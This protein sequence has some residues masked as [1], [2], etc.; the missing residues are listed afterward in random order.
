MDEI[1][2]WMKL[3]I[4]LVVVITG[5]FVLNKLG[6][7]AEFIAGTMFLVIGIVLLIASNLAH[8][9]W[10]DIKDYVDDDLLFGITPQMILGELALI[11]LSIWFF[12]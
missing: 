12:S 2:T 10:S 9:Y 4:N 3:L 1:P 5:G 8:I 11:W 6:Y 7:G